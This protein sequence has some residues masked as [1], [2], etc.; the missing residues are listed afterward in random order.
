MSAAAGPPVCVLIERLL[1][2]SGALLGA[3]G[4]RSNSAC[5]QRWPGRGRRRAGAARL[6]W[7]RSTRPGGYPVGRPGSALPA[8]GLGRVRTRTQKTSILLAQ[9]GVRGSL[10]QPCSW[11]S[12]CGMPQGAVSSSLAF[13][14]SALIP[15]ACPQAP[16]LPGCMS[17]LPCLYFPL[18]WSPG[19]PDPL[20]PAQLAGGPAYLVG[21]RTL[22]LEL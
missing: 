15:E 6:E 7:P 1:C 11:W 17:S 16:A 3:R 20:G 2:L 12:R 21:V 10:V 13:P 9:A 14:L 18:G 22:F 8:R 19:W 4:Q 5:Q